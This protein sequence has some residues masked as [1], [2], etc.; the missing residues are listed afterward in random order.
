MRKIISL[1][2]FSL[3]LQVAFA[4][5]SKTYLVV[6]KD[7]NNSAYLISNPE[8]FLSE[9]SIARRQKQGI[10]INSRDLPVNATYIND[11]KN[12][13]VFVLNQSK[14]VNAVTISTNDETKLA[15]IK[16]LSL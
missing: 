8:K 14:W 3:F 10:A 15:S 12:V 16:Q 5:T 6:F 4:Q 11:V 7:K 1:L 9:K 2:T 13:G